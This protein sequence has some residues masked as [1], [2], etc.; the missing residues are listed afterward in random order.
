V[1][2]RQRIVRDSEA[3]IKARQRRQR[4]VAAARAANRMAKSVAAIERRGEAEELQAPQPAVSEILNRFR[5][6]YE[7]LTDSEQIAFEAIVKRYV[8]GRVSVDEW[9]RVTR[10]IRASY[11]A[12]L[13]PE[14]PIGGRMAKAKDRWS[15]PPSGW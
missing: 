15:P 14:P 12:G 10:S 4:A 6:E 7:S 8:V 11:L 9:T 5:R 1:I 13:P 3:Q 2:F